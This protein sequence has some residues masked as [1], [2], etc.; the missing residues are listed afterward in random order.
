MFCTSVNLA[1]YSHSAADSPK[2]V[3]VQKYPQKRVQP[4]N[5]CHRNQFS[6]RGLL[7][8][9]LTFWGYFWT[10]TFSGRSAAECEYAANSGLLEGEKL[11]ENVDG[12]KMIRRV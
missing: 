5:P 3:K 4:D 6:P 11:I 2:K 7:G 12:T 10:L 8:W 9:T 1:A